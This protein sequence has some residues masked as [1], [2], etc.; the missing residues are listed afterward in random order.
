[1][2]LEP[3]YREEHIFLISFHL[4][5]KKLVIFVLNFENANMYS[6]EKHREYLELSK[7]FLDKPA[8]LE[9]LNELRNLLIF[10]E[11]KYYIEND[12]LISDFEYDGLFK[13]LEA[14]EAANPLF[15]SPDSPT[16]RISVDITDEILKVAHTVPMLSLDNSYNDEDL[17][18]FDKSVKKLAGLSDDAD[19]AY[20]VEPKYDGG[21]IA[22]LYENDVLVRAAT[23]GNGVEG[24]EITSNLK[25]L[26]TIP[27]K[28]RFSEEGI[29][30][31]ELRGEALIRKDNFEMINK[32]RSDQGL[33]MF[34]NPRNA[35]TG[36][37]RT[38]DPQETRKRGLE[39]FIYQIAYAVDVN[40]Q[41]VLK[42]M[43]TQHEGIQ[44]LGKKGFK[45]P[46]QEM[47][48]C[49]NIQEVMDF[50]K[51]VEIIR[52]DLPYEIDGMVIKVNDLSI[53]DRL[54]ATSHHPR[55]AIAFKFKAKQATSQLLKVEYQV[56]KVGSITPVAK[57]S[58]VYLA[59]VTVS[60]ISLHNEEFIRSKDLRIGDNVLVERAGD[61][62]PY[63]VKSFSELR[64]GEEQPIVF[65]EICP[66]SPENYPVKLVQEDGE[67][68][69]RCPNCVCGAQNLQKIIFHVSKEA[70]DIDGFGKSYVERFY[71]LGWVKDISDI[72]NLDYDRIAQL[73][74]FGYRSAEKIKLSIEKA[75]NNP[76]QKL[77][78]SLSIHHLGKRAGKLIAEHIEHVFDLQ[79]WT[80][81]QFT[82]IKDIGPVVAQNVKA[83][84]SEPSNI[85]MLHRMESYGVNLSQKEEDKPLK[86]AEDAIFSD[87][88]I[89][90][91]GTLQTMSRKDAETKAANAGAKNISAVSSNLNILVVGEKA[92]SKLKK[93]QSLG[94][95]EIMTEEE[96]L[97]AIGE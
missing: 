9:N 78:H 17:F 72:Y 55:W 6:T 74:G 13:Q 39:A 53:Q 30:K 5:Q 62:I 91:T 82:E 22:L 90:F 67:A 71:E 73:E 92:G 94:T 80:A 31:I 49:K 32:H 76:I 28:A 42:T 1:V 46:Q 10:H 89:L 43:S 61:V 27:L 88:T 86:I 75:K 29:Y 58:P 54:G 97:R 7:R 15:V 14:I 52:D 24:E 51:K 19:V 93:A 66:S 57:I 38:K 60:S 65:P 77:L 45:I 95:V 40:S 11:R 34:A 59:G 12:P 41:N 36:G 16:Q 69:W 81:E 64:T 25:T 84:F 48:L 8:T 35:A 96:F 20:C 26:P 50:V 85:E 37:L 21:S 63:I 3:T 68:A 56:G 47:A 23:R 79:H 44:Y 4:F 2:V 70:M 83:W 33:Q 18:D 87:K